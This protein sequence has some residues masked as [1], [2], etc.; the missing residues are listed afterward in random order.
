MWIALNSNSS[1][2]EEGNLIDDEEIVSMRM[3]EDRCK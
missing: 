1:R 3:N 2:G